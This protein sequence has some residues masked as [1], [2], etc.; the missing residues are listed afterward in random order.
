MSR[1]NARD[2]PTRW[3]RFAAAVA[4]LALLG[5]LLIIAFHHHDTIGW[6]D[7]AQNASRHGSISPS[8]DPNDDSDCPVCQ[9]IHGQTSFAMPEDV[10]LAVCLALILRFNPLAVFFLLPPPKSVRPQ[11]RAP[12][13][14]AA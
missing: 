1:T 8:G 7:R 3:P 13:H 14:P 9:A 5:Q 10:A 6:E 11:P 12:P 2:T 4:I